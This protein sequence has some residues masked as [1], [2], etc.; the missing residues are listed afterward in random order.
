V[1]R[2]GRQLLKKYHPDKTPAGATEEA[3]REQCDRF[4]VV[5]AAFKL[6]KDPLKRHMYDS[7]W[8][9]LHQPT[10]ASSSSRQATHASSSSVPTDAPPTVCEASS[11]LCSI[12]AEADKA[13]KPEERDAN[14]GEGYS[15]GKAPSNVSSRGRAGTAEATLRPATVAIGK[16]AIG[17][18]WA[19]QEASPLLKKS[20]LEETHAAR[21][22]NEAVKPK[23]QHPGSLE[24]WVRSLAQTYRLP[25][26]SAGDFMMYL[27]VLQAEFGDLDRIKS[28]KVRDSRNGVVASIDPAFFEAVGVKCIH[29]KMVFAIAI[30]RLCDSR[31]A[32]RRS[33]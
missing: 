11:K 16:G 12:P 30:T 4:I 2:N 14:G 27:Q 21:H 24:A 15:C 33:E 17:A 9:N 26:G 1:K 8:A 31:A 23:T 28:T 20:K 13:A 18:R 19:S 7:I 3:K 10:H 25:P 5:D 22:A 6:L 29:H 32:Q